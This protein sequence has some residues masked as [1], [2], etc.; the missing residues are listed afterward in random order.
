MYSKDLKQKAI[1]L[2]NILKSFRYVGKLLNIGKSTI[3]R[4]V[5]N[6]HSIAKNNNSIN[7]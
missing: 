5:N 7:L 6:I 2:Y 3:H 4:W 1:Y